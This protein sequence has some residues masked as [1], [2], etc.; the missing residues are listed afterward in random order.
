M[1]P[2]FGTSGLRGLVSELTP[3]LVCGYVT[4]FLATCPSGGKVFVGRD[5]RES[6]PR[7]A[8]DVIEAV[9]AAGTDAVDCG[10]L[11]TPALALAAMAEGAAAIMVTGSHIPADRNGLKFYLPTGE[12]TKADEAAISQAFAEGTAQRADMPGHLSEAP[13][14]LAAYVARYARAF[15]PKVLTGARIGVYQHSSVA[16]DAMV[17]LIGA[18]GGV[19]VPL[20]RSNSFVPVDTEAVDAATRGMLAGWC[21]EHRLDAVISTDGDADRPMLTDAAGQVVPGDILGVIA[22][23]ALGARIVCTPVSS[24]SM[25]S[26][27]P[28][29]ERV[30]LTRIGS[31]FVIAAMEEVLS[32]DPASPVVGFEANGGFLLGFA[33]RASAGEL[34]PLMT[35]DSLLPMVTVLAA[36]R[37]EGIPVTEIVAAL[38]LRRTA[39]DRLQDIAPES[40]EALLARLAADPAG[41]AAFF[42][43]AGR[44]TGCDLTDGLR[45]SFNSGAIVHLRPSGNAPEFR[46]YA[47]AG[48]EAEAAALLQTFLGRVSEALPDRGSANP[49]AGAIISP[50]H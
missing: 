10:I 8:A 2:K 43:P 6:S 9:R 28:D 4:G 49:A 30:T 14:A 18:L 39:S 16:R 24:N 12:I 35:R 13:Q 3:D 23:R 32:G 11:P 42:A 44:E 27:M 5:L 46:I 7:I 25:V 29:F 36:A 15:G 22:A 17:D 45:V 1:A 21:A 33:A 47:E 34:A 50:N 38:P 48:T 40:S 37:A 20:A 19:P 41:R 26:R 31:P